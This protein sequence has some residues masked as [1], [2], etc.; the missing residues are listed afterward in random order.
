MFTFTP[1]RRNFA[2]PSM[3]APPS[4]TGAGTLLGQ[5]ALLESELQ[6]ELVALR[7]RELQFHIYHFQALGVVSS[8][9]MGGALMCTTS[10]P[11]RERPTM[12]AID[13]AS[14]AAEAVFATAAICALG[15]FALVA[16]VALLLSVYAPRLALHGPD[17]SMHA[18]VEELHAY[19][20]PLHALYGCGLAALFVCVAAY[21]HVRSELHVAAP[22]SA[23]AA[24]SA[25]ATLIAVRRVHRDHYLPSS[26]REHGVFG[27]ARPPR[28]PR[29][30]CAAFLR[31]LWRGAAAAAAAESGESARSPAPPGEALRVIGMVQRRLVSAPPRARA[32]S[33]DVLRRAEALEDEGRLSEAAALVS[34]RLE[35]LQAETSVD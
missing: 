18:T 24:L 2:E 30:G 9:F 25:V 10:M 8:V 5:K 6:R 28:P 34:A 15:F 21:P 33:S 16:T 1:R 23:A 17:S 3:E 4:W 32:R 12:A 26:A 31:R 35:E 13:G 20:A 22:T 19:R 11:A 27:E 7:E 14:L 29:R